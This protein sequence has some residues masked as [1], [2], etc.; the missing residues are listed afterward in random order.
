MNHDTTERED[1]RGIPYDTNNKSKCKCVSCEEDEICGGLW[2]GTQYKNY[3]KVDLETIKIHVIVAHCKSPIDWLDDYLFGHDI[4][5][6]HV[7]TKC[8][9]D[10]NKIKAPENAKIIELPSVGSSDHAYAYYIANILPDVIS[11]D[12]DNSVVAFIKDDLISRKLHELGNFNT[13]E[14]LL[15]IAS[16]DNGLGCGILPSTVEFG[17]HQFILSTYYEVDTLAEFSVKKNTKSQMITY[18]TLGDWWKAINV[19][20]PNKLVQVCYN[21]I[22]AASL[23]NVMAQDMKIW[24][25]LEKT[26]SS[27][28]TQE[29]YAERTWAALLSKPLEPFQI[30]ALLNKSDGVV[31]LNKNTMHGALMSRPKL[32]L[33]IGVYGTYSTELLTEYL[34]KYQSLLK[35]DGYSIAVHGKYSQDSEFPNIDRLASCM[36]SDLLKSVFPAHQKDATL[37][38]DELL[39]Q[40]TDYMEAAQRKS[41]DLI[42]LNPWLVRPGT[43]QSLST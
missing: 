40:L 5:S 29:A 30:E 32:Y 24:K 2:R 10:V 27:S 17:L 8:G 1:D 11:E 21:G 9:E 34:V 39:P 42:M 14:E 22:F 6:M 28:N 7:I 12:R 38:P 15:H 31:Y 43:A 20:F 3:G 18:N 35:L 23:S 33:H 26:L 4:E 16:S 19:T 25:A 13:F 37:C 41:K 36:W